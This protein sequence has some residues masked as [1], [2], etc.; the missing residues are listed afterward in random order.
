MIAIALFFSIFALYLHTLAPHLAP[1]RDAGEM[2][3]ILGTLGVAHPPGYPLYTLVGKIFTLVPLGTVV[4]RANL[5]SAL[6]SAFAIVMFARVFREWMP[7]WV[8]I[9]GALYLAFS[10]PFWELSLVSEMYALGVLWVAIIFYSMFVRKNVYL[11][12]FLM[13]LGL[14]VRMDLLLVTPLVLLWHWRTE[15]SA[16]PVLWVSFFGLGASVFLYLMFRS[17]RN[18]LIDWANPDTLLA[19]V[20]SAMRKNYSGTLDLISLSYARGENFGSSM[21]FYGQH[22]IASFGWDGAALVVMGLYRLNKTN[23]PLL[24][25][26]SAVFLISGPFFLFLANMPP[27]PHS[28]AIVEAAFLVPDV[29]AVCFIAFGLAFVFATPWFKPA[30]VIVVGLLGFHAVNGYAR[31]N[32]RHNF[33]ARDYIVNTLRSIPKNAIAAFHKDVQLFSLWETQLVDQKRLDIGLISTGLSGSDWYWDM[34]KRWNVNHPP[35]ISVK[36]D[37]GWAVLRAAGQTRPVV[38][39]Y[40][41]DVNDGSFRAKPHGMAMEL[42]EAPT[43]MAELAPMI[44][45]AFCVARGLYIY[46]KTPDFFSSDLIGDQARAFHSQALSF[47]GAGKLDA[48]I[49]FFRRSESMDPSFPRASADQGYAYFLKK[50]FEH[51]VLYYARAIRKSNEQLRLTGEYKS[52]P[53]LVNGV[54]T[55]LSTYYSQCGA[56]VDRLGRKE[57]ARAMYQ[58]SINVV[59]NAQARFNLAITYWNQDWQQVQTHL[60]RAVML[61]PGM[62]DAQ[63]YLDQVNQRL[64]GSR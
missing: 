61:N 11:S 42:T 4:Y 26:F 33:Y 50:D 9:F 28:L 12:C 49:Y 59:D 34:T 46:G 64:R 17:W 16:R 53:R 23:R 47:L 48:A 57:E 62:T 56:A 2:T 10:N 13:A 63:K 14:G 1:Y 27:N 18:P 22:F 3:A 31:A 37:G 35:R 15:R 7:K 19:V 38:A 44:L 29:M 60:M 40:D 58:S 5:F 54:K 55:D 6:C 45:P 43:G 8:A 30:S 36:D 39:G 20:N 32:K 24:M 21:L 51:A 25:F 41:I 52:L